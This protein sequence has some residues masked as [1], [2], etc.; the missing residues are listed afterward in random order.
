[1]PSSISISPADM[2]RIRAC[3]Q[4]GALACVAARHDNPV[5]LLSLVLEHVRVF[6]PAELISPI[7]SILDAVLV[8][9]ARS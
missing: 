8:Q 7:D 3:E 2:Q 6:V 5:T 4:I 1:M 9:E